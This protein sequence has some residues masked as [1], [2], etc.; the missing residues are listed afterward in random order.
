MFSH[1]LY[2]VFAPFFQQVLVS[3]QK[4]LYFLASYI[5]LFSPIRLAL[6]FYVNG[7]PERAGIDIGCQRGN[8]RLCHTCQ[9]TV[10]LCRLG[11]VRL[12][13]VW[14]H[15]FGNCWPL[16]GLTY[17][18]V[19]QVRSHMLEPKMVR[20][21][22]TIVQKLKKKQCENVTLPFRP[23]FQINF[24]VR[25]RDI[26]WCENVIFHFTRFGAKTLK[27]GAKSRPVLNH[28]IFLV[29]L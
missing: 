11:Q 19:D 13:Q 25:K 15:M 20:K 24:L 3:Q 21:R 18:R 16:L 4:I 6:E 28:K 2:H 17:V 14:S 26:F 27:F 23:F 29:N 22:I 12:G 8:V 9:R 1:Q 10:C 7:Q 5:I